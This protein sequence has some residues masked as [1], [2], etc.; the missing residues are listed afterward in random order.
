[1][2]EVLTWLDAKNNIHLRFCQTVV[3]FLNYAPNYMQLH[4]H[5]TNGNDAAL[6]VHWRLL[7]VYQRFAHLALNRVQ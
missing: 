5:Q 3:P 6:F 2:E 4:P 1:M 7:L